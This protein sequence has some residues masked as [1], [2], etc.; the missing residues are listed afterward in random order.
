MGMFKTILIDRIE[1]LSQMSGYDA[2]FLMDAWFECVEDLS[3]D[4]ETADE[5]WDY[6]RAVALEH[7]L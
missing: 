2:E 6:F 4:G 7:D 1:T 3:A 5:A